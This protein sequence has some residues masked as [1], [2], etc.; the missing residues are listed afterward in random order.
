[1]FMILSPIVLLFVL[2]TSVIAMENNIP[3]YI[4]IDPG[5]GGI[6]GGGVSKTGVYEKNINLIVSYYLK[7]YLENSGYNVKMTRTGDYDL[8][9]KNSDNRKSEDIN[10]R[11]EIINEENVI[12]YISIH[13]NKFND[14]N[15]RGAQTFYNI[16]NE[17]SRK[18]SNIIQNKL[19]T[20]LK[21]TNRITKD[22]TGKYLVDNAIKTGSLIEIGFLSNDDELK[23]LMDKSYLDKVAYCIYI[24]IIDYIGMNNNL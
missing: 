24:G 23:L 4:V 15:I 5:H 21:N 17:E 1:M 11:V 20:I 14:S 3:K 9:C 2:K 13:C 19:N 12:L 22:I 18:L 6:D 8:A 16:N 10:K 7:L